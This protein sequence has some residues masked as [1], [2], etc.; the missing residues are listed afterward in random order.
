MELEDEEQEDEDDIDFDKRL[1]MGE[2]GGNSDHTD[3]HFLIFIFNQWVDS[4]LQKS[5]ISVWLMYLKL[6][7]Y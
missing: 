2:D 7:N 4:N 1:E 5:F 3:L 6:R